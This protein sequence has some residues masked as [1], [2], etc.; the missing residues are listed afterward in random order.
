MRHPIFNDD[1]SD[2]PFGWL[3]KPEA[4]TLVQA[5]KASEGVGDFVEIGSH[6]GR[7]TIVIG[8]VVKQLRSRLF[9]I[10]IWADRVHYHKF[11]ENIATWGLG[12]VVVPI[13]GL[14][15]V[16]LV[17]WK[18]PVRFVFVDG[19][20]EYENVVKDAEWRLKLCL[21]GVIAFHDYTNV[22]GNFNSVRQ[23]VDEIVV[24]DD[25]FER[26]CSGDSVVAFKK[27]KDG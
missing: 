9:C 22:W 13:C 19:G 7:S 18:V 27:V 14:S 4:D 26:L 16:I 21:G 23:A 1:M 2:L 11:V 25:M 15:E 10:D 12:D 6:L 17:D 20:H 8:G 5:V 24:A 3:S